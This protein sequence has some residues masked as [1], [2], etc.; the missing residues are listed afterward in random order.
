VSGIVT[1]IWLCTGEKIENVN[2]DKHCPRPLEANSLERKHN[3]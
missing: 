1:G 3:F 2:K